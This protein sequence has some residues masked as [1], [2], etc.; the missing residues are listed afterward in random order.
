MVRSDAD[1]DTTLAAKPVAL[2]TAAA[3]NLGR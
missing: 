3:G 2:V 1:T